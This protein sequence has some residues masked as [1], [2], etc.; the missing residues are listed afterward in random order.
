MP[1]HMGAAAAAAAAALLLAASPALAQM[2]AAPPAVETLSVQ[3]R[4]VQ[5][6]VWPAAGEPRAVMA[7]SHGMGGDH[8]AR[9]RAKVEASLKDT[10]PAISHD[11]AIV[12]PSYVLV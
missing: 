3:K 1:R 11:E 2:P 5:L 7:F 10:R 9:F 6:Q 12:L 4:A 8:D